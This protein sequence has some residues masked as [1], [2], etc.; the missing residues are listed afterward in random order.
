MN[1]HRLQT[2]SLFATCKLTVVVGADFKSL[3]TSHNQTRLAILL[4]PQQANIA[5]ATL[6]PFSALTVKFKELRAHLEGLFFRL[7]VGLGLNLL[8]QMDDGL[9]LNIRLVGL[10]VLFLQKQFY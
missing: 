8:R 9:E 2:M 4:V 5:S 1:K 10:W 6:L 3:V 7:L